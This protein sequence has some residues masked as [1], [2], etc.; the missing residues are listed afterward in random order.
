MNDEGEDILNKRTRRSSSPTHEHIPPSQRKKLNDEYS[1]EFKK[2]DARILSTRSLQIF[3]LHPGNLKPDPRFLLGTVA[4]FDDK[5]D[6]MYRDWDSPAVAHFFE[7]NPD[8]EQLLS[9]AWEKKRFGYIQEGI[10]RLRKKKETEVTMEV[11]LQREATSKSWVQDYVGDV[12]DQIWE[13]IKHHFS[14]SRSSTM[15]ARYTAIV[16][17]SGMGKSRAVD[18]LAKTHLAI[19]L[20]LRNANARGFPPSDNQVRDYLT[21]KLAEERGGHHEWATYIRVSAFLGTLFEKTSE[22]VQDILLELPDVDSLCSL[23]LEFRRRMTEDQGFDACNEFRQAFYNDVVKRALKLESLVL[24][25][26]KNSTSSS[27]NSDFLPVRNFVKLEGSLRGVNSSSNA[28]DT[29]PLVTLVF[30]EAHVLTEHVSSGFTQ[31]CSV[32]QRLRTK[33]V[34]SLFLSTTCKITQ[35]GPF[36]NDNLSNR[37]IESEVQFIDPFTDLGFDLLVEKYRDGLFTLDEVTREAHMMKFGRPLFETRFRAQPALKRDALIFA[38][39]KLLCKTY[40]KDFGLLAKHEMLAILSRRIPI[41]FVSTRYMPSRC[42]QE[43]IEEEMR[44]VESHL[45]ICLKIDQEEETVTTAA[46]SE[47][48]LSE[49]AFLIMQMDEFNASTAM[50]D[51]MSGF[52]VSKGDR[53][54]LLILLQAILAR[55]AVVRELNPILDS[56]WSSSAIYGFMPKEWQRVVPLN[57]F[58]RRL[59]CIP[60]NSELA[61]AVDTFEH[62]R[63]YFNH[64]IKVHDFGAIESPCLT[65]LLC[66]GAAVLCAD[67]EEGIDIII[68]ALLPS[69]SP[70]TNPYVIDST[71]LVSIAIS[72]KNGNLYGTSPHWQLCDSMVEVLLANNAPKAIFRI[73]FALGAEELAIRFQKGRDDDDSY[74]IWCAGFSPDVLSQVK[75]EDQST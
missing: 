23:A 42:R 50:K 3:L 55:D 5:I 53:G 1:D 49:A 18:E 7:A 41:E 71:R 66:R 35:F 36:G 17:S 65:A 22:V 2:L 70:K 67:G 73:V 19:P 34:F 29:E 26:G 21:G 45:R 31:L 32:L 6:P 12:P 44:Q 48:L 64:F 10:N 20:C 16:Q 58:L 38:L 30:D 46:P 14:A 24:A 52:A 61:Q 75:V 43:I 33:S 25:P 51:V 9:K 62:A 40:V 63:L 54:V 57:L 47:P 4:M 69:D 60:E 39:N 15:Y 37:T 68:Q 74:D 27:D 28:L 56:F 13:Y 59:L 8:V 72:V 11:F